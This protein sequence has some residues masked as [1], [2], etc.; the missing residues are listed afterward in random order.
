MNGPGREDIVVF[1]E[2]R[3]GRRLTPSQQADVLAALGLDGERAAAFMASF[4]AEFAVDMTGYEARFHHRDESRLLRPGWPFSAPHLFGVRL[5]V[6]VST[7][8]EA[9]QTGRWPVIYPVLTLAP[10]RQWVNA[11]LILIGLPL[12]AA[13]LIAAL[14]WL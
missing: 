2:R 14:R 7:L 5:P 10:S 8:T 3:F 9:A 4:S 11:P 6:A 13:L 12:L 1:I